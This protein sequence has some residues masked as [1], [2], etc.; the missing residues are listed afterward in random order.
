MKKVIVAIVCVLMIG[1]LAVI[2]IWIYQ[3]R[4]E[5]AEPNSRYR[6]AGWEQ[7]EYDAYFVREKMPTDII[8]IGAWEGFDFEIPVRFEAGVSDEELKIRNGYTK[9]YVVINDLDG[10]LNITDEEYELL[11]QYLLN[12]SRYNL[13]YL[14][15]NRLAYVVELGGYDPDHI[16]E[17]DLSAGFF[18]YNDELYLNYG[19]YTT[20]LV[21]M[22][23][24]GEVLCTFSDYF[25]VLLSNDGANEGR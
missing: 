10:S 13:M 14:G 24:C 17:K 4:Q 21:G 18:R 2:G 1:T 8:W 22:N 16:Q 9:A 5:N 12:D 3:N 19:S 20:E 25:D 23:I 11:F 15:T 7:F 6:A